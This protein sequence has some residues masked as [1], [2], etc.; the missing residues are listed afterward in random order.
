[1]TDILQQSV[2]SQSTQNNKSNQ[3]LVRVNFPDQSTTVIQIGEHE[4]CWDVLCKVCEKKSL[5]PGL[6]SLAMSS[7]EVTHTTLKRRSTS[8]NKPTIDKSILMDAEKIFFSYNCNTIF[9]IENIDENDCGSRSSSRRSST[10]IAPSSRKTTVRLDSQT[11][12]KTVEITEVQEGDNISLNS[13]KSKSDFSLKRGSKMFGFFLKGHKK[14][15]SDSSSM[16]CV[17]PTQ[18][19]SVSRQQSGIND[20]ENNEFSLYNKNS[21]LVITENVPLEDDLFK[22]NAN[23][24]ERNSKNDILKK[25]LS[26]LGSG[27]LKESKED[28]TYYNKVNENLNSKIRDELTPITVNFTPEMDPLINN[29][30]S[31]MTEPMTASVIPDHPTN[32]VEEEDGV[33]DLPQSN[34]TIKPRARRRACTVSL[35]TTG[36]LVTSTLRSSKISARRPLMM[37]MI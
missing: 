11:F 36:R 34:T 19:A 9:L 13:E 5:K 22:Q 15:G 21:N 31:Y 8:S 1:M 2:K 7:P 3:K 28:L 10:M 12:P 24:I 6:F 32:K 4:T 14:N 30:K 27:I 37:L 16:L 29:L 26:D 35:G 17:S 23:I 18:S 20:F 25:S 33:T